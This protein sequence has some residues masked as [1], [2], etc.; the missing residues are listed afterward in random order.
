MSHGIECDGDCT[1]TQCENCGAEVRNCTGST[2]S[3]AFM[4]GWLCFICQNRPDD[5]IDI[6]EL[7]WAP[8]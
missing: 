6:D 2:V 8:V 5:I 3:G 7:V 1:L 4:Q